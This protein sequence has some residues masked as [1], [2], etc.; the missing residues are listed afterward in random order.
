MTTDQ[1]PDEASGQEDGTYS[2]GQTEGSMASGT[3]EE[4]AQA[5]VE[6][7]AAEPVLDAKWYQD[8]DGNYVPDFIEV[9]NGF[10]PD[11]NDCAPE[12][13]PGAGRASTSIPGRGT[14]S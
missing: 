4:R 9:A 8:S 10:D 3:A 13:C 12:G 1:A 6:T 7:T 14:R 2:A 5:S 11:R